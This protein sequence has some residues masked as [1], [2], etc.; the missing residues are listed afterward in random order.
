LSPQASD[1]LLNRIKRD[2]EDK[3][4]PQALEALQVL[5]LVAEGKTS[6]Q[7]A[8]LLDLILQTVRSYRMTMMAKLNVSSV[9]GLRHLASAAGIDIEAPAQ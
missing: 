9:A 2:L 3:K 4:M 6:K 8:V 7:I 1:R 5:R